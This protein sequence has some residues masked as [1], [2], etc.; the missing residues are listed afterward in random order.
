MGSH[1]F[2]AGRGVRAR[3]LAQLAKGYLPKSANPRRC[4]RERDVL[5]VRKWTDADTAILYAPCYGRMS[6]ELEA[7]FLFTVKF[8]DAGNWK[9]VKTHQM[10]KM[11]LEE[12]Q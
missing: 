12:A 9:I 1:A 8:D 11:E 2:T 10:S 6:G 4:D 7:G 5:K 3:Q